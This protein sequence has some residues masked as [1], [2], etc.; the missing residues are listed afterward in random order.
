MRIALRTSG[1]RGEYE[2][3]G[4]QAGI[5]STDLEGKEIVFQISPGL[6]VPGHAQTTRLQGKPRIRLTDRSNGRH[7]HILLSSIFLM[8]RPKRELAETGTS[9]DVLSGKDYS[10]VGVDVDVLAVESRNVVLRP[11]QIHVGNASGRRACVDTAIRMGAIHR[12]WV[13]AEAVDSPLGRLVREHRDAVLKSPG[14]HRALE[15]VAERIRQEAGNGDPLIRIWAIMERH[16]LPKKEDMEGLIQ[17]EEESGLGSEEDDVPPL[18][19]G[20]EQVRRWRK[21]IARGPAARRFSEEVKSVYDYRCLFTGRRLPPTPQTS[22]SGVESAHILPWADH[23]I[24]HVANGLCLDKLCHWAFDVGILR[25]DWDCE[26]YVLTVP[27]SLRDAAASA[28][29]DLEFFV[30]LEGPLPFCRM[31]KD[32]RNWPRPAFLEKLNSEMFA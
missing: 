26:R 1:G 8:P 14:L 4:T 29:F 31:P 21:T 20:R 23:Q 10:I 2:L 18:A 11:K 15:K 17:A 30:E 13:V 22:T 19:S 16:G 12:L 24:D 9:L 32:Q 3:V 7:S 5:R 6:R 28:R 27:S 25:L